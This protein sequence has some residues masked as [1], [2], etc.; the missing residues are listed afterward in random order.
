MNKEILN[1]MGISTYELVEDFIFV[2][3]KV[4]AV[5]K[6]DES[7]GNDQFLK[8]LDYYLNNFTKD[9]ENA[10]DFLMKI[11]FRPMNKN[12]IYYVHGIESL[13]NETPWSE[14]NFYDALRFSK[15]DVVTIDGKV[16]GYVIYQYVMDEIHLLNI[17]VA[18]Q[19]IGKSIG[20]QLLKR[21]VDQSKYTFKK[22]IFLE[23]RESNQRAIK[24]YRRNGFQE[25]GVRKNY[26]KLNFG[27]EDGLIMQKNLSKPVI[28]LL[29]DNV[30]KFFFNLARFRLR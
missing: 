12:D 15:A 11:N 26:Y 3:N 20:Y 24:F 2:D 1:K 23:V 30:F 9:N 8:S 10:L 19:F 6:S 14:N 22:R 25:A 21:V 5:D 4:K 13:T 28:I 27:R 29:L 18:P 7:E 17:S 16:N